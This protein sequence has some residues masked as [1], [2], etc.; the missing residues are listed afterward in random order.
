MDENG[1]VDTP[2]PPPIPLDI[3]PPV[4]EQDKEAPTNPP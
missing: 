4:L 2:D 3:T 1:A